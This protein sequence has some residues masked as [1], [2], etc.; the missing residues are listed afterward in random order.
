MK[1]HKQMEGLATRSKPSGNN[2]NNNGGGGGGGSSGNNILL[3]MELRKKLMTF[4]DVFDVPPLINASVPIHDLLISTGEDLHRMYPEFVPNVPSA[5]LK[6]RNTHQGLICFYEVLNCIGNSEW[7][8]DPAV[9]DKFKL[10][11]VENVPLEELAK[12]VVAILDCINKAA[13]GRPDWMDEDEPKRDYSSRPIS[14]HRTQSGNQSPEWRFCGSPQTPTSVLPESPRFGD[15]GSYSPPRLWGL[16]VQ[17]VEKLTPMDWK[18]LSFHMVLQNNVLTQRNLESLGAK[19][20]GNDA[21][22][23]PIAMVI[24]DEAKEGV[25]APSPPPPTPTAEIEST[26]VKMGE[27]ELSPPPQEATAPPPP[28]PSQVVLAPLPALAP[29]KKFNLCF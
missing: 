2:N 12:I 19:I 6:E 11:N 13:K 1:K 15:P 21:T 4:R 14:I 8:E 10:G 29:I 9:R 7:I 16:R 18:R 3:F 24:E 20:D 26:N 22:E 28:L 23:H 25:I 5:K 17:A 27:I